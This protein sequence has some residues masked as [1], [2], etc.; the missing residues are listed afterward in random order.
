ML[1]MLSANGVSLADVNGDENV[2]IKDATTI[3]KHIA[4][5]PIEFPIGEPV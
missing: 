5:L 2:N 1:S 4:G 3:Q